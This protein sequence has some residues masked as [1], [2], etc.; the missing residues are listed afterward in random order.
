MQGKR[1]SKESKEAVTEK[2]IRLLPLIF[3]LILILDQFTKYIALQNLLPGRPVPF[4]GDFLRWTLV[5]NPG[6]A[7]SMRL[8]SSN[9]YLAASIVIFIALV[10]YIIRNR[11]TALL[12]VPLTIVAGGA[13]GNIID[14]FR[15]GKVV[16]FIDC[17]FFDIS[18]G[19]YHMDRWPI[20]NIADMA[21]SCGIISV[22]LLTYFHNWKNNRQND[23]IASDK[24]SQT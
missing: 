6:G 14:R 17:E 19:S 18:I 20:F 5:F 3:A 13:A 16:D 11:K 4:L 15:F 8:G 12:A 9:Y 24:I 7:F 2:H 23:P 22:I 1:R 10:F 21:V